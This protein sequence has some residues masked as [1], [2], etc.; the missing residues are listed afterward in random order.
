MKAASRTKKATSKSAAKKRSSNTAD[1][2]V[3]TRARTLIEKRPSTKPDAALRMAGATSPKIIERLSKVLN[4]RKATS[5]PLQAQPEKILRDRQSKQKA[6][7][8]SKA[9]R[10]KRDEHANASRFSERS[11]SNDQFHVIEKDQPRSNGIESSAH[12]F[13]LWAMV[14]R[15]SPV[16]VIIWQTAIIAKLLRQSLPGLRT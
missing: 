5:L 3:L 1:R 13:N 4:E 6:V 7:R 16:P 12:Q 10:K 14:L 2:T 15:W 9:V 11:A 8:E